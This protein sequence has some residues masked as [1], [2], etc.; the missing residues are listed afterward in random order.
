MNTLSG[1]NKIK[2][3]LGQ[4]LLVFLASTI[5]NVEVVFAN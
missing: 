1:L 3:N 2:N 4:D 5:Q